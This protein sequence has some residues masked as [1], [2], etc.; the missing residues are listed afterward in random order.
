MDAMGGGVKQAG[1]EVRAGWATGV[2]GFIG[3]VMRQE[4]L[5]VALRI[6]WRLLRIQ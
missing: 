2:I 4:D 6:Q 1:W 5:L 3:R